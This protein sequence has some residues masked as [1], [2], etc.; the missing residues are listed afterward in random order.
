ME[1]ITAEYTHKN[2]TEEYLVQALRGFSDEEQFMIL[3]EGKPMIRTDS[4]MVFDLQM[5]VIR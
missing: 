2:V 4:D 3:A 5:Q 1:I